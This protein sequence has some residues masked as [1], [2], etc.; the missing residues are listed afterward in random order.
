[1]TAT[2]EGKRRKQK[3]TLYEA[4]TGNKERNLTAIWENNWELGK[5]RKQKTTEKKTS[6]YETICKTENDRKMRTDGLR[7]NGTTRTQRK[8]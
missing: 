5:D 4:T 7:E 8:A 6:I 3:T 2:E 1:M